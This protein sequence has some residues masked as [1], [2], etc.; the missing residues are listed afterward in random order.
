MFFDIFINMLGVSEL[1][2]GNG[3]VTGGGLKGEGTVNICNR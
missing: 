3:F 1:H 2:D